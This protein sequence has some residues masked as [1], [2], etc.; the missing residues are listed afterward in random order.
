[1]LVTESV[2]FVVGLGVHF[3][4]PKKGGIEGSKQSNALTFLCFYW[5]KKERRY[6]HALL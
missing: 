3:P 6:R 5:H 1:M 2:L 4:P